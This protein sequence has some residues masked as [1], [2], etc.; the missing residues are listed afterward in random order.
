LRSGEGAPGGAQDLRNA[1]GV[2]SRFDSDQGT[3]SAQ[4]LRI[5]M[6]LF[7]RRAAGAEY[8]IDARSRCP[9]YDARGG[10]G[11]ACGKPSQHSHKAQTRD[12][13]KGKPGDE[14]ESTTPDRTDTGSS[15]RAFDRVDV[16]CEMFA[17][18]GNDT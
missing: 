9:R 17:L 14:T 8:V 4:P 12:R 7:F 10:S 6:R 13:H 15:R 16:G 2:P 1:I 5:E 3:S 18:I 11:K